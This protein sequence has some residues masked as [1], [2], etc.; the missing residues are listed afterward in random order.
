MRKITLFLTILIVSLFAFAQP[1]A[2]DGID[3]DGTKSIHL[4][5]SKYI[6]KHAITNRTIEGWFKVDNATNRQM[7]VKEG[8][9][10]RGI[11][12]YVENNYLIVGAFNNADYS[13][14]WLGTY[15]RKTISNNTWYHFAIVFSGLYD[16][17]SSNY[18]ANNNT[19][20]KFYL[21][22]VLQI[23]KSGYKINNHGGD[24]LLGA[25]NSNTRI[26]DLA[27]SNW[28]SSL[29]AEYLFNE[30]SSNNAGNYFTG[31]MYDYMGSI[32]ILVGLSHDDIS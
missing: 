12:I 13:P 25:S 22:G 27:S 24:V 2:T 4:N 26:V 8:G 18:N 7:V 23:E 16:A 11:N 14:K 21:D 15:Y 5:D 29:N 19:N 6:N 17:N 3:F 1:G 28:N 32:P 31:K 10:T 9:A 30:T 20:F